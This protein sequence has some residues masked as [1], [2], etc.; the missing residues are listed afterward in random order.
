MFLWRELIVNY[1]FHQ[2]SE[3]IA[4]LDRQLFTQKSGILP[5]VKLGKNGLKIKLWER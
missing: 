4:V 5:A 2:S 1:R 3:K